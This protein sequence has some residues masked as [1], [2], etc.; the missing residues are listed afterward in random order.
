MDKSFEIEV[1]GHRMAIVLTRPC[2]SGVPVFFLHGIGGSIQFWAPELTASFQ[3]TGPCYSLSLPG[4]FPA[5][6][7]KGFP[8]ECLTAELI[9]RLV[10]TS[11]QKIV[12]NKKV[13]LVGHSTGGFAALSAAIYHPE[14]VTGVVSIAGFAQGQWT[15]VLGFCQW[16]VR[17]GPAGRSI[18]KKVYQM[19][20]IQ[21]AVF[22]MYWQGY[23]NDHRALLKS[24]SFETVANAML[25]HFTKLDMEAMV[26]YFTV[27]PDTDI[28]ACLSEINVPIGLIAGD[29]DPIVPPKQS[30]IIAGKVTTA[31]LVVLK[32]SGHLPFFERPVEYKKAIETW[33]TRFRSLY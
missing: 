26:S 24:P 10:S 25:P 13:L 4:H 15:G 20:S 5:V 9:A 31:E 1:E 17:Q 8:A 3:D 6:F 27:M 33:L 28:T 11:I 29:K 23:V 7:R 30:M 16:L 18:F 21:P 22:R 19:G 32:G 14:V 2:D 12:G